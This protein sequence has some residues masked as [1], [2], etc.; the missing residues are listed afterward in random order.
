MMFGNQA[1]RHISGYIFKPE[2]TRTDADVTLLFL[3]APRVLYTEAIN[4]PW[5]SAHRQGSRARHDDGSGIPLYEQD[6][7]ASVLG[8]V[9][10]Y[11]VCNPISPGGRRC[12]PLGGMI[13]NTRYQ[14][15]ESWNN[16]SIQN[17]QLANAVSSLMEDAYQ[18]LHEI[19]ENAGPP[20]L[21]AR[22]GQSGQVAGPLPDDQWEQEV[23]RWASA[24]ANSLQSVFVESAMGYTGLNRTVVRRP[25]KEEGFQLCKNQ[26]CCFLCAI[27]T[28]DC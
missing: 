22:F 14:F 4:D 2:L 5:Y 16:D 18:S 28:P 27:A 9:S 10:Q 24:S 13:E 19:I 26:V 23:V 21:L 12:L 17:Q 8:C 20:A 3:S 6:E 15:N 25:K 7:P 1:S 11:Q